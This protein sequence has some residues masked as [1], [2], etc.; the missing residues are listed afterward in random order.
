MESR[1]IRQQRV[2]EGLAHI[3]PTTTRAQHALDEVVHL[4]LS[5]HDGRELTSA[6]ARAEHARGLVEPDLLDVEILEQSV[7]RAISG[8][9]VVDLL[10]P[11]VDI[12]VGGR[13]QISCDHLVE[14]VEDRGP[15]S[16]RIDQRIGSTIANKRAYPIDDIVIAT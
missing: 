1:A 10:G 15:H 3:D 6:P 16:T 2:N 4:R 8:D 12:R 5:E 14:H 9:G 7:Q 11:D 13:A